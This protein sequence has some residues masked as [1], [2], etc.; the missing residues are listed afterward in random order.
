MVNQIRFEDVIF[1]IATFGI[2]NII[3]YYAE[4]KTDE[5]RKEIDKKS[6]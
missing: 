5:E 6:S 1:C 2:G 3:A 4:K